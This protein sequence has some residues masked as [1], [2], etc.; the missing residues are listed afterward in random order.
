MAADWLKIKTDYIKD[1]TSSLRKIAEKYHVNPSYL[2]YVA[3]KEK[4]KD[5]KDEVH[6]KA[7]QKVSEQLPE[8]IAQIKLRH[9]RIGKNLQAIGLQAFAG[10]DKVKVNSAGEAINA[11]VKGV[12]IERQALGLNEK[13]VQDEVY[14][15][16]SQFTFIFNL[17]GTELQNFIRSA[18]SRGGSAIGAISE[19]A[20]NN[21]TEETTGNGMGTASVPGQPL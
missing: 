16:F 1:P 21:S 14:Q 10:E 20:P 9:A 6:A 18:I 15:K 8:T 12:N 7:E 11:M 17:N 3:A 19:S 5:K 13:E 2:M 4:W